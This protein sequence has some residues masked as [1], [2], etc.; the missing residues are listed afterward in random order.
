MQGHGSTCDLYIHCFASHCSLYVS[1]W[2]GILLCFIPH[3]VFSP[4]MNARH[5]TKH[6]VG[7][8]VYSPP[9]L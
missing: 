8:L 3:P 9:C 7:A 1:A 4:H 5:F 6:Y 2:R